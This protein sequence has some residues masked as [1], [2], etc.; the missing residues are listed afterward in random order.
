VVRIKRGATLP[1]SLRSPTVT[2]EREQ[3]VMTAVV[4]TAGPGDQ[5]EERTSVRPVTLPW[6]PPARFGR[7]RRHGS[8]LHFRET[9]V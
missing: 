8:D 9:H 4:M 6:Q 2:G 3:V 7:W 1:L 5:Q